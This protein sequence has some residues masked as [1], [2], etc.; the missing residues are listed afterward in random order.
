MNHYQ[1]EIDDLSG[2]HVWNIIASRSTDAARVVLRIAT[3]VGPFR[4]VTRPAA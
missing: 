1:V 2:K 4:M 3:I